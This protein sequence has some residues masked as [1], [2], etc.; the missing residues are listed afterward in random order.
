M[1][2]NTSNYEPLSGSS[3]NPLPKV[4]NNSMKGLINI[5]NKDHKCFLWRNV[6]LI[7]PHDRNAERI[8]KED[9]KIAAKLTFKY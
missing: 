9:K 5:K 4:S 2:I 1:Y 6:R 7:N 3:Y 8:S